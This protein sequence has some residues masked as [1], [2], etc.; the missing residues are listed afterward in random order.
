MASLVSVFTEWGKLEEVIVGDCLN[1]NVDLEDPTFEFVYYESLKTQKIR[2]TKQ[3]QIDKKRLEQRSK[4]LN[5]LAKT[6]ENLGVIVRRPNPLKT[7]IGIRTPWFIGICMAPDSPRDTVACIGNNIIET[8]PII[9]GRYFENTHYRD[10]FMEY[11]K[12]G[13]RWISAPKPSL[14]KESIEL[15]NN[16]ISINPKKFH[17]MEE[18]ESQYEIAFD[19]ANFLKIGKDILFNVGCKNHELG[20]RWLQQILGSEF[21]VHLTRLCDSHIDGAIA[22]LAPGKILYN[23][24][25]NAKR[26]IR[27]QLPEKMKKWDMIPTE[28]ERLDFCWD[29]EEI[30]LASQ[31]GMFMNV[32]S[33]NETTIMIQDTA[34]NTIKSLKKHGFE[35]IP[36]EFNQG[37]LFSGGLHCCTIDVRRDDCLETFI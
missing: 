28:E 37:R 5:S 36:I 23:P 24:A 13:A 6:L 19:A 2:K 32:L 12:N 31:E 30:M 4:D 20:A 33:I 15:E 7:A 3:Y 18:I 10:I 29:E 16:W 9:R 35:V 22:L 21:N 25:L 11:F 17:E 8:P 1:F 34:I 26:N 27:D 14:T